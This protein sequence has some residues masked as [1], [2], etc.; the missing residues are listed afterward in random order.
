MKGRPSTVLLHAGKV[1]AH[2]VCPCMQASVQHCQM[3]HVPERLSIMPLMQARGQRC[4]VQNMPARL[5][6]MTQW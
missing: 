3:Q 5:S 6:V 1:H 2:F 4:K